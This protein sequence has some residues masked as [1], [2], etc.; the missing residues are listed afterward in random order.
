MSVYKKRPQRRGLSRNEGN[1]V[2]LTKIFG[3]AEIS[4][5]FS[6][7]V[8]YLIQS[9]TGHQQMRK[10]LKNYEHLISFSLDKNPVFIYGL[11]TVSL[12]GIINKY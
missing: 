2:N 4:P 11:K 9:H 8:P 10:I 1:P 3:R 7:L 12:K 6:S 5:S